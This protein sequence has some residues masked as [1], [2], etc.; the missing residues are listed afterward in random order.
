MTI[1]RKLIT[2]IPIGIIA[3]IQFIAIDT[4]NPEINANNDCLNLTN[5][6]KEIENILKHSCYDG[7]SN[8]TKYPWYSKVV[9][10]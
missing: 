7:H 9:V 2:I 1:K 3:L 6:P 5:A 8:Q 10:S 4:S